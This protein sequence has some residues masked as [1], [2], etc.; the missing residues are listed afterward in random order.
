MLLSW[1]EKMNLTAI[2]RPDEIVE[3]H[4]LDSLLLL[5]AKEIPTGVRW[6][7]VGTGAGFPGI[8]LKIARPDIRLTLLDSLQKR[9]T[10]LTE[11][12]RELGQDNEVIHGRAEELA[13]DSAYREAFDYASAR[14]VAALPLLCEVCLPY[15]REGGVFCAMKGPDSQTEAEA[16]KAGVAL[17]G[18]GEIK[19]SSFQLPVSGGRMIYLIEKSSQTPLKYPR[20]F[21]QMTKKPL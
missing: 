9:T 3:K 13:H 15:L 10:F 2:T 19:Q 11:L 7:D 4:F 18:G 8:P 20:K 17:L 14:A 1:N 21:N 5:A 6:V 12:S 16:A